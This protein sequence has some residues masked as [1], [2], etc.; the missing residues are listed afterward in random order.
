MFSPLLFILQT[1]E[2]AVKYSSNHII[3][4]LKTLLVRSSTKTILTQH[5][6]RRW[7]SSQNGVE[8]IIY[9]LIWIKTKS[10]SG[11]QWNNC[12]DSQK[13]PSFWCTWLRISTGL[14]TTKKAEQHLHFWKRTKLP[15]PIIT[16]FFRGTIDTVLPAVS[17]CGTVDC[18]NSWKDHQGLYSGTVLPSGRRYRG[19]YANS[20]FPEEIR[21]LNILLTPNTHLG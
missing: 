3:N 13:Q 2:C 9:L 16:T 6:E 11:H 15:P 12:G 10:P 7:N 19:I 14:S 17:S 21:L 4:F 5:K 1:H 18:E 20:F 8:T